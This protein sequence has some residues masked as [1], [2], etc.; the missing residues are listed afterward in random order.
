MRMRYACLG[1]LA[2]LC[3]MPDVAEARSRRRH[4]DHYSRVDF[5]VN[6]GYSDYGHRHGGYY[7]DYSPGYYSRH[8]YYDDSCYRP[9]SYYRSTRYYRPVR[10]YHHHHYSY[11]YYRPSRR[12]YS[13]DYGYDYGG[14][15]CD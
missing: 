10:H 13:Y 6:F 3:L 7:R 4:R 8:S 12:C 5:S 9:R 15:Y 2:A 14:R 11:D 1:L